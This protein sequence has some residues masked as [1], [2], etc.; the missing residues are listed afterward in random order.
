MRT[1]NGRSG[2]SDSNGNDYSEEDFEL[3]T[4]LGLKLRSPTGRR[5]YDNRRL[6]VS[7]YIS[8][9]LKA[10][11]RSRIGGEYLEVTIQEALISGNTT[12]IKLLK[13][14]RFEK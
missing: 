1:S 10:S 6:T 14:T 5:L 11:V 7:E 3:A 8:R 2:I 9:F 4:E 13:D 12:V